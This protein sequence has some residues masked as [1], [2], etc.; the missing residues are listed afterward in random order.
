M[1]QIFRNVTNPRRLIETITQGSSDFQIKFGTDHI[2]IEKQ[3]HMTA[4]VKGLTDVVKDI[5]SVKQQASQ[6][7]GQL[8]E[9]IGNV[10]QSLG[11]VSEVSEALKAADAELRGA[12][13]I[14]SNNPPTDH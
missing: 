12:L 8:R 1:R 2:A 7:A 3:N 10:Q 6:V 14:Q 9:N 11:M 13:G 5:S 4:E